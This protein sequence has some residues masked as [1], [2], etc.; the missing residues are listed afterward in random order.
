MVSLNAW[1]HVTAVVRRGKESRLYVNGFP[2]AKGQI[3]PANL[4]DPKVDLHIGRIP[5]GARFR[6]EVDEVHIYRRAL[7]EAEIQALVQP[8]RL[9]AS[10]PS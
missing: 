1:Q 10:P 6:G 3:G 9:F 4:D 5:E 2:V 7:E 8:G